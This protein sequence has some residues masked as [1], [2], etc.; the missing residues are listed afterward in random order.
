MLRGIP[1]GGERQG[2][3]EGRAGDAEE[4]GQAENFVVAV[5]AE[6]PGR[7]EGQDDDDLH[8]DARRGAA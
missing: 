8:G 4:Q 2:D 5:D 1:A 6:E 7:G 3:R